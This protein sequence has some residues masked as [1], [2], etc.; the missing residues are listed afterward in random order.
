[1]L[2]GFENL[3]FTHNSDGFSQGEVD[4]SIIIDFWTIEFEGDR[5]SCVKYKHRE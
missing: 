1:M 5:G 3:V 4:G 2:K